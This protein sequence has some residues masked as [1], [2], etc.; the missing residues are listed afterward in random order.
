MRPHP[1]QVALISLS[2]KITP[3]VKKVDSYRRKSNRI[4]FIHTISY[5]KL[6]EFFVLSCDILF[7][8]KIPSLL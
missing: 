8:G 6:Y 1:S 2:S 4:H 5:T 7:G 3:I